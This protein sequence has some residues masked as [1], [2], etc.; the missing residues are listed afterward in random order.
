MSFEEFQDGYDGH[1]GYQN[2]TMLAILNLHVSPIPPT[3]VCL[4]WLTIQEQMSFEYFQDG[5]HGRYQKGVILAVLNLYVTLMPPTKFQHKMTYDLGGDVV[6]RISRLRAW[7]PPWILEQ[8]DF[9]NFESS[10][11]PNDPPKVWAQ[12]D[13]VFGS[14]CGLKILLL[15][16]CTSILPNDPA[17]TQI[18]LC[19]L[20]VFTVSMKSLVIHDN[21]MFYIL[22]IVFQS[23]QDY[24]RLMCNEAAH[25]AEF[26]LQQD[27]NPGLTIRAQLFKTNDVV[28]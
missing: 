11:C 3:K 6:W 24:G 16:Q 23:N 5:H 14:R 12:S 19:I 18:S 4:I 1:L 9:S 2:G 8:K 22:W 7:W 13:L 15:S 17:K 26:C 27:L 21:M 25:S 28:S 10:C 20:W